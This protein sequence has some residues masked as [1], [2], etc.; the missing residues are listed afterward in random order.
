MLKPI[1][2]DELTNIISLA[3]RYHFKVIVR[4]GDLSK[5]E[6]IIMCEHFG[7][8]CLFINLALLNSFSIDNVNSVLNVESGASCQQI[9]QEL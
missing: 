7:N 2:L 6:K 8:K 4:M 1:T 5:R 3:Y 9:N